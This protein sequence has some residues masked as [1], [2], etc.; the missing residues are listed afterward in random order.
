MKKKI[1]LI[2]LL[3]VVG[4]TG[5]WAQSFTL[6][7][8]QN[9]G[10]DIGGDS[11]LM[12]PATAGGALR[13]GAA[14][15][16]N[17]D[18]SWEI[19]PVAYYTVGEDTKADPGYYTIR[20]AN[21]Y[22]YIT[23][24]ALG[25]VT[26]AG[27]PT[28]DGAKWRMIK[29]TVAGVE[30]AQNTYMKFVSK[31]GRVL[32]NNGGTIAAI[33]NY[34]ATNSVFQVVTFGATPPLVRNDGQELITNET[35]VSSTDDTNTNLVWTYPP[36]QVTITDAWN[37]DGKLDPPY[38]PYAL[39][40]LS[41]EWGIAFPNTINPAVGALIPSIIYGYY[42]SGG[43]EEDGYYF[44]RMPEGKSLY[45][46]IYT[47]QTATNNTRLAF[48]VWLRYTHIGGTYDPDVMYKVGEA[49]I[50]H[51]TGPQTIVDLTVPGSM[52]LTSGTDFNQAENW[53]HFINN[54]IPNS[55]NKTAI[56]IDIRTVPTANGASYLD[57]DNMDLRLRTTGSTATFNYRL[58]GSSQQAPQNVHELERIIYQ[59]PGGTAAP[60]VTSTY[61]YSYYRWYYR[62]ANGIDT[63][64][65]GTGIPTLTFPNATSQNT[66]DNGLVVAARGGGALGNNIGNTFTSYNI[67]AGFNFDTNPAATIYCDLGNYTNMTVTPANGTI[68]HI[69][70][71]TISIRNIFKFRPASEIAGYLSDAYGRNESYEYYEIDAPVGVTNLRLTPQH[72]AVNYFFHN[73]ANESKTGAVTRGERFRWYT[74]TQAEVNGNGKYSATTGTRDQTAAR[75]PET[76][77]YKF[78]QINTGVKTAGTTEYYAV[79]ITARGNTQTVNNS[80]S[81][82]VA[83]F[84]VN[85]KAQAAVGP[86][87]QTPAA[88][89]A[90]ADI[91]SSIENKKLIIAKTFDQLAPVPSPLPD[92]LR[93]KEAFS[94]Y[95]MGAQPLAID[96]SSYGFANP[97]YF[98][99]GGTD[100][101]RGHM[102][103]PYWSEYG[104]PQQINGV[105]AGYGWSNGTTVVNDITFLKT[106]N[107]TLYPGGAVRGNMLYIDA[108]EIPGTVAALNFRESLCPGAKLYCSAWVVNLNQTAAAETTRPNLSFILKTIN[109][110]GS[111]TVVKRYYTGDIAPHS[112]WYQVG[113]DFMIPSE[114][115]N[116]DVDF[117]LEVINNGLNTTGNDF[118]IDDIRVYRTNP[119]ISAVR[120]NSLFCMPEGTEIGVTEPLTMKTE[121]SLSQLWPGAN[122]EGQTQLCFRFLDAGGRAFP[123][124]QEGNAGS[125]DMYVNNANDHF[126]SGAGVEY[127]YWYGS[128]PFSTFTVTPAD[129]GTNLEY[130]GKFNIKVAPGGAYPGMYLYTETASSTSATWL[131]FPQLIPTSVLNDGEGGNDFNTGVYHVYVGESGGALLTPD[132]AG[133]ADF[134]IEFDAT[135][136]DIFVGGTFLGSSG[137]LD[138]CTN[139]SVDIK[140]YATDPT[141]IDDENPTHLFSYYDWYA[142][143]QHTMPAGTT[144]NARNFTWNIRGNYN[145]GEKT[146]DD[147]PV[148]EVLF[149]KGENG[150]VGAPIRNM[151]GFNAWLASP[152]GEAWQI[153]EDTDG[154]AWT[155]GT[156]NYIGLNQYGG[157][158]RYTDAA[159]GVTSATLIGSSDNNDTDNDA[160]G[161]RPV[162]FRTLRSDLRAYRY[163]F[164]YDPNPRPSAV[165]IT[166]WPINPAKI[167]AAGGSINYTTGQYYSSLN[168]TGTGITQA[169]AASGLRFTLADYTGSPDCDYRTN[170]LGQYVEAD[171]KTVLT[172]QDNPNIR[173]PYINSLEDLT[174]LLSRIHYYVEKN[175]IRLYLDRT[176]KSVASLA[177]TYVTVLPINKAFTVANL[178]ELTTAEMASAQEICTT[179]AQITMKAESWSPDSWFG[180]V[181]DKG[182]PTMPYDAIDDSQLAGYEY[183]YTVRLPE[184]KPITA[185]IEEQEVTVQARA[186]TQFIFPLAFLDEIKTARVVLTQVTNE[187]GVATD[188]SGS[189]IVLGETYIGLVNPEDPN[190][191]LLN[192]T[193]PFDY[194]YSKGATETVEGEPVVTDRRSITS[195]DVNIRWKLTENRGPFMALESYPLVHNSYN[196]FF[197]DPDT[198]NVL[199][200]EGNPLPISVLQSKFGINTNRIAIEVM[201]ESSELSGYVDTEG[202][203][204]YFKPGYTYDFL[205]EATGE[206][207]WGGDSKCDLSV[208]FRLKVVPDKIIWGGTVLADE[209]NLDNNWFIPTK[210]ANGYTEQPSVNKTFSPLPETKVVIPAGLTQYPTLEEYK[211]L[212]SELYVAQDTYEPTGYDTNKQIIAMEV[213][214]EGF[215]PAKYEQKSV[216]R[217]TP[218]IE[219]DYNY[220]PNSADTIY[221]KH[222]G[223]SS[224]AELGRPDLLS[225][226]F[227]KVDLSLNAIQWYGISA[228]LRSMYSGD[229]AFP[230]ANPLSDMRLHNAINPQTQAVSSDWSKPF[231][232][233]TVALEA[234]M[235]YSLNI[236][237]L[238]LT[239][240]KDAGDLD[241]GYDNK[242]GRTSVTNQTFHFPK[243]NTTFKYYDKV[244]KSYVYSVDINN[245]TEDERNH[246]GRFIYET[247]NDNTINDPLLTLSA[248]IEGVIGGTSKAIIL[249]NPFMSHID[250][251]EF[252]EVNKAVI[253]PQ[254]KL[255]TSTKG[256]YSSERYISLAGEVVGGSITG[257]ESTDAGLTLTS[258]PP[259][260]SFVVFVA[261][262][263]SNPVSINFTPEMSVTD[264]S[265]KLRSTGSFNPKV[266]IEV[267]S[268]KGLFSRSLIVLSEN[269]SVSYNVQEDSRLMLIE[270][271]TNN[272]PHVYT[273][274]DNLYLDINRID[275][276]PAFLPLGVT[277]GSG[278]LKLKFS[279]FNS[280]NREDYNLYFV[281]VELNKRILIKNDNM[282]YDFEYIKDEDD[283]RF[284]LVKE[285]KNP[286]NI[287]EHDTL[288]SIHNQGQNIHIVS[289]DGNDIKEVSI[290]SLSGVLLNRVNTNQQN[291][292]IT[293]PNH[294]TVVIVKVM[295]NVSTK[296]RKLLLRHN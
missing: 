145:I 137:V 7:N 134:R 126:S 75:F 39:A 179:P 73:S 30:D 176:D 213:V 61:S 104:F 58:S 148:E 144:Y 197:N 32:Y 23:T 43:A 285:L 224:N 132:C 109:E 289:L 57:V 216:I 158:F 77:T 59:V 260:Q 195:T 154:P 235:A 143:P 90:G 242:T 254:Y 26:L 63:R 36:A 100:G 293:Q 271:I 86:T 4:A 234:G 25:V 113:F 82:R 214:Q 162:N 251:A 67:P 33:D 44:T 78:Y 218:F 222:G 20:A 155:W 18:R 159:D 136:F 236:G 284:F 146:Q 110:D 288:L 241:K 130:S 203:V 263:V 183:V 174:R 119:A 81:K 53:S 142:G 206:E 108:S 72:P 277:G 171:G 34:T 185:V 27:D 199:A 233:A 66:T 257:I 180:E 49:V 255:L 226:N 240:P 138:I 270:G 265:S 196:Y 2:L 163:F 139:G 101:V 96:E 80:N 93:N 204:S 161:N 123:R 198:E 274:A 47:G 124:Y 88:I 71:P 70:E 157:Y 219:F 151:D 191:L 69:N 256:N 128:I 129:A 228:P 87:Q 150:I 140:A 194:E 286:T 207:A 184:R 79:D 272:V 29:T 116:T 40:P 291:V 15:T 117:R 74:L 127:D 264:A 8:K 135:D 168:L 190:K 118:A 170:Y 276:F 84:K 268:S 51:A 19:E 152:Q 287:D 227:A 238:V 175:L 275:D 209:W 223:V 295:T 252:Y 249:G 261:D 45:Q 231:N 149:P 173:I 105:T 91:F 6:Q 103:G 5:T 212:V 54:T 192:V 131:V 237:E 220:V 31:S 247:G 114:Y 50:T 11:Y 1:T 215:D 46:I 193:M 52:I 283:G 102:R 99:A 167:I 68:T 41:H 17:A 56:R 186:A 147:V 115:L 273:I 259:M 156:P 10:A 13:L 210:D 107:P 280:L 266:S 239:N 177:S 92:P 65:T 111:E 28:A 232:T 133:E 21:T 202:A 279:G 112:N 37:T 121:V 269:S 89:T 267:E 62:D 83:L 122:F 166:V 230:N 9:G 22:N 38:V 253:A 189:P 290:Y 208:P 164:P 169:N 262:G 248:N 76:T 120:T 14:T 3:L 125:T 64:I 243:D 244:D 160:M 16:T 200:E 60:Q 250:F 98:G 24:D 188:L 217:T 94:V 42:A 281:D 221:F 48:T 229:Y 187:A 181:D 12:I 178:D 245:P 165:A 294:H 172:D 246:L 97:L 182:H 258:I 292:T 225:Y 282:E 85:Y 95:G 55:A 296:I 106:S 141:T 153:D 211:H 278:A 35:P 205:F 201:A